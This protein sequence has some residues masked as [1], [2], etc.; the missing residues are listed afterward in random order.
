MA[1][2]KPELVLLTL[3]QVIQAGLARHFKSARFGE[4]CVLAELS[5]V[6]CT[7][8]VLGLSFEVSVRLLKDEKGFS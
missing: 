1:E 8:Q 5:H 4:A 3:I 7:V 6:T 2:V